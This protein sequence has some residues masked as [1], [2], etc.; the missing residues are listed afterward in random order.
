MIPFADP[1][2]DAVFKP[3]D[4]SPRRPAGSAAGEPGEPAPGQAEPEGDGR[5][6]AQVEPRVLQQPVVDLGGLALALVP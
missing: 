2:A 1:V 6:E 5:G 4:V 3:G